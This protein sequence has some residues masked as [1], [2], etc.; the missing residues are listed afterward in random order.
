MLLK[1]KKK[2]P[3]L[4][5]LT[6]VC[7]FPVR[8]EETPD[9]Y[10]FRWSG[11]TGKAEISLT[12]AEERDGQLFATIQFSG[13]GGKKSHYDA[14]R[15][16]GEEYAGD[17]VFTIPARLNAN[18]E[19]EARTTA[20]SQPHWIAY[21]LYVGET[22]PSG[23]ETGG[24]AEN[25]EAGTAGTE[26][27]AIAGLTVQGGPLTETADLLKM[28]KYEDAAG[29]E[30]I[31]ASVDTGTEEARRYLIVPAGAELPAGLEK[32]VSVISRPAEHVCVFAPEALRRIEELGL[33]D[34]IAAAGADAAEAGSEELRGKMEDGSV[35]SAGTSE[36]P[37]YRELIRC[38]AD[39]LIMPSSVF[40]DTETFEHIAARAD[41]LGIPLLIDSSAE[42]TG[43]DAAADWDLLYGAVLGQE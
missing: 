2:L 31:L 3:L 11:G 42:E 17:N 14:V 18:T 32:E 25:T 34:A 41:T 24:S 6:F 33:S 36:D 7:A 1:M 43:E 37:D 9:G 23:A 22:E 21:T 29:A 35:A 19:I 8:A 39:L 12:G 20:M 10:F 40:A 5:L 4:L 16:G 26:A 15:T 27:P 38:G 28:W 13:A 30:Y